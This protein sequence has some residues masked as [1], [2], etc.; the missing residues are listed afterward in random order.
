MTEASSQLNVLIVGG[1]GFVSGTVARRAIERGHKVWTVTRGQRSLPEGVINLIA[2]RQDE[3]A[4]AGAIGAAQATW[5]IVIDCIAFG[6]EAIQQDLAL[7]EAVAKQLVFISSDFVYAPRERTFPQ[8]EEAEHY[9]SEGY[10]HQKRLAEEVLINYE[11][12]LPWS[13]VRPCHIYGPG[14]ELGCLPAHGRDK[15]LIK[16]MQAGETLQLVGGGYFLQQPIFARD[17]ADFIL[18][19]QGNPKAYSQIFNT[20]GPDVIESSKFYQIIADLL[21]VELQIEELAVDAFLAENPRTSSF[22]CH[23][24]NDMSK[25]AALGIPLPSTS[26][27]DGLREHVAS[28]MG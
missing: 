17:L 15:E 11:G 23:R 6:P 18:A 20:A 28:M 7:F 22:F 21:D 19:L 14:S 1:S 9:L 10:G 2:D 4:F 12:K 25:A 3:A 26:I 8:R 16:R 27:E 24:L 5:D 13:V